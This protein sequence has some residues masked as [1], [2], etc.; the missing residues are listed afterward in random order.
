[1]A[2][3]GPRRGAGRGKGRL[4]AKAMFTRHMHQ[5][6]YR[7]RPTPN[8][9][10][11]AV[12]EFRRVVAGYQGR[13]VL[14]DVTFTTRRGEFVGITGP[15]GAGKTTLLRVMMGL[16]VPQS[17]EARLFEQT[18]TDERSRRQLRR[19]IGYVPQERAPGA[20]PITV[21]DAVLMGRWGHG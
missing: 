10:A 21:F 4:A 12:V 9:D 6:A 13:P 3:V 20:L 5:G 18:W 1:M 17:G 15:N 14:R 7:S 19:K 2:R 11:A 16:L 8:T